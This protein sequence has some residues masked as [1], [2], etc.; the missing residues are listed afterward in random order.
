MFLIATYAILHAA[1]VRSDQ[2]ARDEARGVVSQPAAPTL[3]TGIT[4]APSVSFDPLHTRM[5]TWSGDM[6]LPTTD[7]TIR[8]GD[9]CET[10]GEVAFNDQGLWLCGRKKWGHV[11]T[12][13]LDGLKAAP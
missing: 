11:E 5:V 10:D 8:I 4:N 9:A 2:D 6:Y 3:S 13:P 7:K 12:R 1:S